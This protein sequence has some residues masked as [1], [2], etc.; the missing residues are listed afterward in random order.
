MLE[1]GAGKLSRHV[2]ASG[3]FWLLERGP[4]L[5]RTMNP[6]AAKEG[7]FGEDGMEVLHGLVAA[8]GLRSLR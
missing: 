7:C 5:G 4:R 6:D 8:T 2:G 1:A 3:A